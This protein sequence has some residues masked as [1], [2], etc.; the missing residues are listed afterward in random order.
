[1][2]TH[3]SQVFD[4]SRTSL[5]LPLIHLDKSNVVRPIKP[6]CLKGEGVHRAIKYFFPFILLN[7]HTV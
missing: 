4:V 3:I 1:M 2:S 7:T 6:I 5:T